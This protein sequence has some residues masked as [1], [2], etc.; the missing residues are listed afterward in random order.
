MFYTEP[1]ILNSNKRQ[2]S[3]ARVLPIAKAMMKSVYTMF[4]FCNIL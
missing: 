2:L 4:K 1:N 3:K